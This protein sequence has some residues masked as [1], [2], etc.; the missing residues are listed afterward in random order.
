[1][2]G[3]TQGMSP[4][5]DNAPARFAEPLIDETIPSRV[6]TDL[7]P[8]IL[9][10]CL[11]HSAVRPAAMPET[12][13]NENSD[14]LKSK[15]KIRFAGKRR[16]TAP[17]GDGVRAHYRNQLKFG[18]LVAARAYCRHHLRSHGF[19]ENIGHLARN[20]FPPLGKCQQPISARYRRRFFALRYRFCPSTKATTRLVGGS[21]GM[22]QK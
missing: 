13:V 9:S 5:A 16:A 11:G 3:R 18:R 22:V 14:A 7:S 2:A 10:V 12:A 6:S 19:R 1:M 21:A 8:P 4:N 17:T 20:C 15:N